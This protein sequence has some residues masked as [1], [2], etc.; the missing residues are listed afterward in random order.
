MVG[1]LRDGIRALDRAETL[2]REWDK[3][4]QA[5]CIGMSLADAQCLLPGCLVRWVER[6]IGVPHHDLTIA[7]NGNRIAGSM[8][9]LDGLTN[10]LLERSADQIGKCLRV[11]CPVLDSIGL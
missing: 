11:R 3:G 1:H 7:C 9:L 8:V 2:A 6:S 4:Q 5:G 10:R